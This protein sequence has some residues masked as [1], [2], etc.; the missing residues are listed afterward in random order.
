LFRAFLKNES[1]K[2]QFKARFIE[3]LN[4]NLR[5]TAVLE[6]VD[7]LTEIYKPLVA[8]KYLKYGERH[9][10]DYNM[11]VVRDYAATRTR[12]LINCLEWV[13]NEELH[14]NAVSS[15]KIKPDQVVILVITVV[16]LAGFGVFC[17]IR[18]KERKNY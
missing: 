6:N 2:T 8:E 1:F 15:L 17:L 12:V 5:A 13:L 14:D 7:T 18:K 10:I 9:P 11:T 4:T 16:A 3:L